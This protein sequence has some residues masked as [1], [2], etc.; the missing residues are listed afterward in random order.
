MD[1]GDLLFQNL[2]AKV[3]LRHR[4]QHASCGT[5]IT[6]K[7]LAIY[8]FS[9]IAQ[10]ETILSA[11]IRLISGLEHSKRT[12]QMLYARTVLPLVKIMDYGAILRHGK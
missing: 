5:F 2:C 7:L 8:M 6:G 4:S 11:S 12:W 3:K 9:I 10:M 1:M